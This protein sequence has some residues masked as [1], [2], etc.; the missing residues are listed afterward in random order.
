M[1]SIHVLITG[2]IIGALAVVLAAPSACRKGGPDE[3]AV[4]KS[5]AAAVKVIAVSRQKIVEKLTYTGILEPWQKINIIPENAGKVARVLVEEGQ[6]VQAGQLLAELDTKSVRLQLQQAEAGQAV[7]EANLAN[8]TKNM[9]RM[10]RLRKEKA[11]SDQQYEQVKL[12]YDAAK[13]QLDQARAGVDLARHYLDTSL[14]K[15]P[16]SGVVASRNAQVG[17]VLNPMMSGYSPAAGIVTLV[18]DSRIKVSVDVSSADVSRLRKGLPAVLRITDA[19]T[20]D[21]P[22]TVTVLNTTADALGKKFHVEVRVENPGFVLRSGTFGTVIFEVQSRENALAIPAKAVLEDK[23]VFVVENGKAVRK[24]VVFGLKSAAMLEVV[25]GLRE[26]DAVVVE[27]NYG[28]I[29]GSAVEI[30]R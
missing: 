1:K 16:W 5:A 2:F 14:M 20:K 29:E 27:G 30:K 15:A 7:A 21:Y 22:G 10:E 17:D 13:A 11:V 3:T 19:G 24:E 6:F 28:L 25:N 8:L 23:Y 12:G 26:G 9:E 4:V 18:D